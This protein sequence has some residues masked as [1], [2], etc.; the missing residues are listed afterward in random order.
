MDMSGLRNMPN[1]IKLERREE[2][3]KDD[4]L[5]SGKLKFPKIIKLLYLVTKEHKYNK[6]LE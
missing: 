2:P 6:R 5:M 3:T 4:Q 1:K